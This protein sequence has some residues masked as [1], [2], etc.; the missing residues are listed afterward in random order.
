MSHAEWAPRGHR[1]P[2]KQIDFSVDY[3]VDGLP[4]EFSN[5]FVD[6]APCKYRFNVQPDW[7][8]EGVA[9]PIFGNGFD[10]TETPPFYEISV[11]WSTCDKKTGL[12]W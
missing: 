3:F 11:D 10:S 6:K 5:N 1:M 9:H 2:E 8:Q 12:P 4:Y 7:S